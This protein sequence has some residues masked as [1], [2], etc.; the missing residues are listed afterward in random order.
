MRQHPCH[1]L[2]RHRH[3]HTQRPGTRARTSSAWPDGAPKPDGLDGAFHASTPWRELASSWRSGF[4]HAALHDVHVADPSQLGQ[5]ILAGSQLSAKL[6]EL[7]VLRTSLAVA[8]DRL[9]ETDDKIETI[10]LDLGFA[11]LAAV[12]TMFGPRGR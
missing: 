1:R 12:T 2:L 9:A 10:A 8:R 7:A 6:R 4:A 11:S 5:S 3:R